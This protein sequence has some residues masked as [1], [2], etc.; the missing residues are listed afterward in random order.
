MAALLPTVIAVMSMFF[1]VG[2][3]G[4]T[5]A[6][7]PWIGFHG[8]RVGWVMLLGFLGPFCLLLALWHLIAGI[9]L[10]KLRNWA[11]F[12]AVILAI[13]ELPLIFFAPASGLLL[14]LFPVTIASGLI[15]FYLFRPVI[16]RIFLLG[17]GPATV[18]EAEFDAIERALV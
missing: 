1:L 2:T 4:G 5:F 14:L 9:G 17:L 16:A 18:R 15:L 12:N 11:R 6:I 8:S 13:I 10:L 3:G 7:G